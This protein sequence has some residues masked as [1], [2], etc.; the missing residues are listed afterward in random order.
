MAELFRAR[1]RSGIE[2]FEKILAIKRILPHL[3]GDRDFIT[4]FINEAKIAAQLTHENVVQIF[5]FGKFEESYYL[6]MEYVWGQSVQAVQAASDNGFLPIHLALYAISRA[7]MGLAYAHRKKGGDE[8]LQIIHRD[9]SPQNILISYEGEVKL[10][11][12]GIAKAAVQSS[13]TKSGVLKGKIPYMSPE[14]VMGGKTDHR[15]DIFSLGV[16]LYELLTGQRLFHGDSEFEM[17][18][19][20]RACE[21]TPPSH[22]APAIP[23]RVEA[24][25]L[26]SLEK[27]PEK[28]YQ[29]A[30]ELH[31]DVMGYLDHERAY[32]GPSD[33][34]SFMRD[35]FREDI[36]HEELELQKEAGLVRHRE[37]ERLRRAIQKEA[38]ER[39]ATDRPFG[40]WSMPLRR[41]LLRGVGLAIVILAAYGLLNVVGFRGLPPEK[42]HDLSEQAA[43]SATDDQKQL[44]LQH[45]IDEGTML[46]TQE[47]YDGAI[48]RFNQAR[49]ADP[50]FASQYDQLFSKAFFARGERRRGESAAAA[51]EDFRKASE[52]DPQNFEAHFE[53][54]RLL[55]TTKKYGEA[56]LSYQKAIEINPDFPDAHFNLGYLYFMKKAY[57][58]AAEEFENA[59]RLKPPYLQ[60]A[61]H[62]L[63]LSYYKLG[64]KKRALEAFMHALKLD[65]KNKKMAA[66]V[67]QLKGSGDP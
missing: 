36:Q 17:I 61:Y 30:E 14:Q 59:V 16:V 51:L 67:R 39:P 9:I 37:R 60:D 47:D 10:V 32:L 15:T 42:H 5:D 25:V 62:N 49:L 41:N 6:A 34:R 29:E 2:G 1:R 31:D 40:H 21:I 18:E 20:V 66:L 46:L 55:T 64:E 65:P 35:R 24:I 53:M 12:F 33:L 38:Y 27:D 19:K 58:L 26:K 13:E 56:R 22:H 7:S 43:V 45:K 11:D 57:V 54:G 28:R 48:A 3:S 44:L 8:I 63:G 52:M 23:N 50:E 4:M